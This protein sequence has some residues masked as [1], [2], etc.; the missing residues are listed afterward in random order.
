MHVDYSH[1]L[2]FFKQKTEYEMR[3][4][5]WSSDVCSSDLLGGAVLASAVGHRVVEGVAR[6]G[7]AQ[8]RTALA[9]LR[10]VEIARIEI[11]RHHRAPQQAMRALLD[12]HDLPAMAQR[13]A[14]HHR[15]QRGIEAGAVAAADRKSVV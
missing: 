4:S 1:K 15:A 13:G 10:A 2:L 6:I 5:D 11:A 9:E 7:R 14:M 3:I 12:A 8:D